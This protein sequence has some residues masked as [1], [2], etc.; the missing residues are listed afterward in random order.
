MSLPPPPPRSAREAF[1]R[2][3]GGLMG[4]SHP[5]G[6]AGNRGPRRR[7]PLKLI[8]GVV[9]AFLLVSTGLEVVPAVRAGLHDG[10]RGTW[11]ATTKTC[12]GSACAWTGKF[13]TPGGRV[14]V[15]S[16]HYAGSVPVG[17]RAGTSMPGLFTGDSNLVFP[18]AGSD[19]WIELVIT[20]LASILGLYW[21]S[22]AWVAERLNGAR[23]RRVLAPGDRG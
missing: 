5:P 7:L 10:T 22:R 11:I 20:L 21:A 15:A 3:L 19:L 18:P 9:C 8:V 23:R 2:P 17:T 13:V 12:R 4:S 14:V 1:G 16:A 6:S